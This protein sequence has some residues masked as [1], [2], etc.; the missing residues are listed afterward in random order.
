VTDP[1]GRRYVDDGSPVQGT[2]SASLL[3]VD[4]ARRSILTVR[5]RP[6]AGIWTIETQPGSPAITGLSTRRDLAQTRVFARVRGRG[7]GRRLVYRVEPVPGQRV[8]FFEEGR[9]VG[10]RIGVAGATHGALP[11]PKGHGTA[12]KRRVFAIVEQNGMPRRRIA[13]TS[14]VAPA[15]PRVPAPGACARN[16]AAPGSS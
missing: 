12:G 7:A 1:R 3:H 11:F 4:R 9:T 8:T 10:R 16:C 13:L 2:R 6:P 15:A 5:G 14:Y